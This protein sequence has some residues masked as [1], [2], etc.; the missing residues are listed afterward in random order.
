MHEHRFHGDIARL[1]SPERLAWLE[2]ERVT[3]A[4]IA[5]QPLHSALDVGTG[6]GLFAEAFA[7][8]GLTVDGLDANPE[9]LSAAREIVQGVAFR[10]GTAEALP[11]AAGSFDLVFMGLLLHETD[12]QLKAM[13]EAA[14]VA[15]RRVVILEW[16]YAEQPMGPG[17]DERLT[18]QQIGELAVQ[19]GLTV[20][21]ITPLDRLVLYVL[22]K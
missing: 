10:E 18:Q 5:G 19:A 3:E 17:L 15:R 14:R 1:R 16:P 4:A 11:Y 13:Q 8:T 20:A 6:S 9:M 2:V 21:S 7:K 12:D 22:E